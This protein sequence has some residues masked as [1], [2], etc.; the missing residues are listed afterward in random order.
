MVRQRL[1]YRGLP[2]QMQIMSAKKE[3]ANLTACPSVN[4]IKVIVPDSSFHGHL[5]RVSLC[6]GKIL[7]DL[8]PCLGRLDASLAPA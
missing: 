5:K 1:L 6:I 3:G 7:Y 4:M 8:V 2:P